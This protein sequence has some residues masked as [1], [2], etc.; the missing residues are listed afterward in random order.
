[1]TDKTALVAIGGRTRKRVSTLV[2][3]QPVPVITT[4][5]VEVMLPR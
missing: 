3:T 2:S 1:M 5:A 4:D